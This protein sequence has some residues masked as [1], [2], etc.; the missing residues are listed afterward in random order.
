MLGELDVLLLAR[1][2]LLQEVEDGR[3][4]SSL[5]SNRGSGKQMRRDM[6]ATEGH[7]GGKAG[8]H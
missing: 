7:V 3:V 2:V 1:V 4:G 6:F 8:A 5:L